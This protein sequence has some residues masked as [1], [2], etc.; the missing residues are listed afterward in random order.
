[1]D[2]RYE[3]EQILKDYGYPVLLVRQNKKLRC[4]CWDE[5]TQTADRE[6]PV[7]FGLGFVPIVE[8]HTAREEAITPA[9]SFPFIGQGSKLGEIT[10]PGKQYYFK[11]NAQVMTG[12]LIV[13]VDWTDQGK[14]YY[15]GRGVYEVSQV[16]PE[17]FERGQ[18]IYYNVY[19]KDQP[20]EKEVRGIRISNVNG[21]INY[22]IAME[23]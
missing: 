3:F 21:I 22:E 7:C 6:C 23:G 1:M 17:R 16:D 18:I 10:V 9:Q 19:C 12:D 2:L 11:W 13:D 15:T 20:V 8:K 5:K 4:S 14:P